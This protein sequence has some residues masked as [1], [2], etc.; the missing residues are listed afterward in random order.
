MV[1]FAS[2]KYAVQGSPKLLESV[3]EI[4]IDKCDHSNHVVLFKCELYFF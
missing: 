1:L 3:G 4:L 2:M